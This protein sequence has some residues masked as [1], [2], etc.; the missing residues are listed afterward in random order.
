[1]SLS[2]QTTSRFRLAIFAR[3]IPMFF[4]CCSHLGDDDQVP[5]CF[6]LY[7]ALCVSLALSAVLF[8]AS[9][10]EGARAAQTSICSVG[11]QGGKEP[12]GHGMVFLRLSWTRNRPE[13]DQN[14][15]G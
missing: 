1:M 5:V 15:T 13:I 6:V 8:Q 7:G 14:M 3:V 11:V 10:T 9:A 2:I 12:C 4:L